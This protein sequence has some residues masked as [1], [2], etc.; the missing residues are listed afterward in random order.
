MVVRLALPRNCRRLAVILCLAVISGLFVIHNNSQLERQIS[1]RDSLFGQLRQLQNNLDYT[2]TGTRE[3][4]P[5]SVN[6][7]SDGKSTNTQVVIADDATKASQSLED[8]IFAVG[9]EQEV[10]IWIDLPNAFPWRHCLQEYNGLLATLSCDHN[11][12]D[13]RFLISPLAS[14]DTERRFMWKTRDGGKCI[15]PVSIIHEGVSKQSVKLVNKKECGE[16]HWVWTEQGQF[17][18]SQG[19]K[20]C[21]QSF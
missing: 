4:T 3:E 18:W 6:G 19:C 8:L 20:K 13:Q 12:K 16:G 1:F 9:K 10:G 17:Q 2:L 7:S 5:A 11:S 14:N 21:L 15:V